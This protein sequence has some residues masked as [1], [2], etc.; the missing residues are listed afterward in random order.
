MSVAA[1]GGWMV[2]GD[3]CRLLSPPELLFGQGGILWLLVP[4]QGVDGPL[5][6]P[7]SE[8]LHSD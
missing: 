4:D 7:G 5:G 1:R 6:T 8:T 2:P 3:G